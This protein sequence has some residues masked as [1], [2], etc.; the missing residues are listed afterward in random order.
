LSGPL[1]DRIDLRIELLPIRPSELL[2]NEEGESSAVVRERVERARERQRARYA[3]TV[4]CNAELRAEQVQEA[5]QA[6][7]KALSLLQTYL[8]TGSGSARVG[9]RLLKVARTLA[10]LEG[11]TRVRTDHVARA[12]G[13]RCDLDERGVA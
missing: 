6:D 13:L 3:D 8:E 10:D 7:S 9:R 11:A 5:A 12:I 1:I 4:T 2:G